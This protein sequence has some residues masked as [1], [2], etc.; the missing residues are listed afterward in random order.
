MFA[1]MKNGFFSFAAAASISRNFSANF[2]G[3]LP[4]A[5][6]PIACHGN[7][8]AGAMCTALAMAAV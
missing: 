1:L 4:S 2:V 6:S 7:F 5:C 8:S 3:C